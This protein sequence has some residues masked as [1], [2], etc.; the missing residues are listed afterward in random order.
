MQNLPP[1]QVNSTPRS[2]KET[3]K[4]TPK[5]TRKKEGTSVEPTSPLGNDALSPSSIPSQS[6]SKESPPPR[7]EK[8][9]ETVQ[10]T[11][12]EQ[13][14]YG[15]VCEQLFPTKPPKITLVVKEQCSTLTEAI[16]TPEQLEALARYC[17]QEQDL[18]G[19]K[20]YLGNL[21]SALDG[22]L[23]IRH[24]NKGTPNGN[25]KTPYKSPPGLRDLRDLSNHGG[26]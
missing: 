18:E 3:P 16:K 12:G 21:V 14:V 10:L 6:L 2:E 25:G 1:G 26:K 17:R 11:E 4:E 9:K 5:E 20:L 22:W 19:K 8:P 24:A 13:H 7:E 23:Q 15:L